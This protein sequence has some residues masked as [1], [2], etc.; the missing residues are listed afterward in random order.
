VAGVYHVSLTARE[1]TA[2][3]EEL[4]LDI[5]VRVEG[6]TTFQELVT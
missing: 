4:P 6:E 5:L 2:D 3:T 1:L